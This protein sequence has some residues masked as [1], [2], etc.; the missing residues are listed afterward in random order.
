MSRMCRTADD[1]FTA[2]WDDGADDAPLTD[3]E[4]TRLVALHG[5]HLR[6]ERKAS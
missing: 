3:D 2:G 4:I 1:A 6:A 5:P